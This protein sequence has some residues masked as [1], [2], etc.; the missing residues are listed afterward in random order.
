V[1]QQRDGGDVLAKAARMVVVLAVH[2][3]RDAASDRGKTCA[4]HHRRQPA[5]RRKGGGD[6]ADPGTRLDLQQAGGGVKAGHPV[7]PRHVD[8]PPA[9]VQ[10]RIAIAAAH[11]HG[12][13]RGLGTQRLRLR[14][15]FGAGNV[16]RG[17]QGPAP[18]GVI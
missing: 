2:I 11:P 6:V 4:R 3:L 14:A 1:L 15:P 12:R 9:R 8:H 18:P 7:K 16:A 10:R 5:A 17:F 13:G